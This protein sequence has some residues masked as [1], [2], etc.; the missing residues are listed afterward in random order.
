MA[1]LADELHQLLQQFTTHLDAAGNE[2]AV[3][4]V[5]ADFGGANGAIRLKQKE[6][7]KSAPNDQKRV[8]GQATNEI[9]QMVDAAFEAAL[10]RLGDAAAARDLERTVDVTLPGRL[11]RLGHLHPITIARRE[12]EEIFAQIGFT[13]AVGPQVETDFHNFEAL[14]MPKDHPARD[15][16]D[17][18]YVEGSPDVV[19]RTH[20]S[21]VQIRTMLAKQP[22]VR[23]IVPGT[24]YR[25]DDDAT[26]SPMFNQVEGLCV[27]VGVTFADLKGVLLHFARRY[28]GEKIGVRLR[29]SFFPF[30]EPSAEID[31]TCV[32][33]SGAGCRTCKQTGWIEIGGSGMVDPE[34]FRQVGYDSEK[35]TGFAF[36][37]GIDRMAM[38]KYGIPVITQLFEG[39]VRF[40]RQFR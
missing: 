19:L 14:A 9:L 33:C 10:K 32:F 31:F 39:D 27:D 17:T 38:L 2:Q 36:G 16:Q 40:A 12:I 3:R 7:L 30:T 21:P 28:F 8:I 25:R 4:K 6:L 22:P 35:Y 26:H 15:M 18:F 29:P 11:H 24:V 1:A 37:W 34:V 23:V 13:V 20:T 5:Y